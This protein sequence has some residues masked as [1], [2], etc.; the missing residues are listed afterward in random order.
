[1]NV[2]NSI[3]SGNTGVGIYRH[4]DTE[5]QDKLDVW[6]CDVWGNKTIDW[7]LAGLDTAAADTLRSRNFSIQ[8][9]FADP[10]NLNYGLRPGSALAEFEHQTVPLVV[11]YRP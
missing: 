3:I 2:F 6:Q 4:R 9:E 8:P 10:A 7:S 1:L 11:G 5:Y